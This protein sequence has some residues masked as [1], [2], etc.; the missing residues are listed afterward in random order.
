MRDVLISYGGAD[1][2]CLV[3]LYDKHG[4]QIDG[5]LEIDHFVYEALFG[6][7]G[8]TISRC[9]VSE[10]IWD[11]MVKFSIKKHLREEYEA[12]YASW[13]LPCYK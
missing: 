11:K 6:L 7:S 10:Q 9:K 12:E 3:F 8:V 5:S 13:G 4:E 2:N 1:E